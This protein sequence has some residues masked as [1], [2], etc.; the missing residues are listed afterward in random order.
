MNIFFVLVLFRFILTTF[1]CRR[2]DAGLFL[3]HS[4]YTDF[5][6][7]KYIPI[8]HI[9]MHRSLRY[10][11]NDKIGLII[12]WLFLAF[13]TVTCLFLSI[14]F[15][16]K[17]KKRKTR[18]FFL[19]IVFFP[20]NYFP[21]VESN[22]FSYFNIIASIKVRLILMVQRNLYLSCRNCYF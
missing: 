7:F 2:F 6:W 3:K 5:A 8:C 21:V 17:I 15:S 13:S 20:F 14:S 4:F 1:F 18:N 10:E 22:C 11:A 9:H 12:I 16:W 19:M